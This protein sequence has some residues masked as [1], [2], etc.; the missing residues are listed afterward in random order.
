MNELPKGEEKAAEEKEYV[1]VI[2]GDDGLIELLLYSHETKACLEGRL[3]QVLRRQERSKWPLSSTSADQHLKQRDEVTS[4]IKL[5][6][7]DI[8]I[9]D[10]NILH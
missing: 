6:K 9:F 2:D 7:L 4:Q 8:P 5:P 1:W 3:E 10:G